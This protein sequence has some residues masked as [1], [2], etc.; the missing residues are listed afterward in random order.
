MELLRLVQTCQMYQMWLCA[1]EQTAYSAGYT[2]HSVD[3]EEGQEEA[4]TMAG[5]RNAPNTTTSN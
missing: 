4:L 3:W 5:E 1:V 2:E